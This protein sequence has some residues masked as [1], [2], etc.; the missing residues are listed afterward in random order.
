LARSLPLAA[1]PDRAGYRYCG[2]EPKEDAL[3]T[4]ASGWQRPDGLKLDGGAE[5]F[6]RRRPP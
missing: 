1:P 4:L 6:G 3:G 2:L 5:Y